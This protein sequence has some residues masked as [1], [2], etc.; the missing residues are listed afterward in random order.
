VRETLARHWPEYVIEGALLGLFMVSACLFATLL[1]HPASPATQALPDP[2]LRR[3]L[4][5]LAMGLTAI[6][7]I[8]SAWGQQSGA[9]F[10][11]AVTL[12]FFRLGRVAR[13]D[14]A[15]YIGAQFVGGV[16][17]VGLAA[18][19]TRGLVADESVNFAVTVPGMWG[20][21]AAFAAEGVISAGLMLVVLTVSNAPRLSR[22]TGLFTGALV[23]TYIVLE[24]PVSGMSMNPA[25]TFAS[26]LPAN[27]WTGL[28]VYLIAPTLGMLLAAEVHLR[29]RRPVRCAKLHHDNAR[30]C[31]FR[32]GFPSKGAST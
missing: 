13:W 21:G 18:A 19:V 10:N 8:Y 14:A 2:L 29:A 20:A 22:F 16:L 3:G 4:M 32:C 1:Y 17:G 23:A 31:I 15:F 12:T 25:R 7:L 11:P 6:A 30:R 9:H 27:V 5:G 26:A 28:W 24:A